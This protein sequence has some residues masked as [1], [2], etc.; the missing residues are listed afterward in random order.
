MC[1]LVRTKGGIG[2]AKVKCL[3]VLGLYD[4]YS[5]MY[6]S[7]VQVVYSSTVYMYMNLNIKCV[8]S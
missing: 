7:Y 5:Q 4:L 1:A 3:C 2:G 8:M 6:S